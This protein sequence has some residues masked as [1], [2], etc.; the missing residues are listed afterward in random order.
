MQKGPLSGDMHRSSQPQIAHQS[1]IT[2]ALD[3]GSQLDGHSSSGL[4]TSTDRQGHHANT[5]L[6]LAQLA[7]QRL[8]SL[9]M[10]LTYFVNDENDIEFRSIYVVRSIYDSESKPGFDLPRTEF[11]NTKFDL[12]ADFMYR[13]GW[14]L[15][16]PYAAFHLSAWNAHFPTPVELWLWRGAGLLLVGSPVLGECFRRVI[17]LLK[18]ADDAII[19]A[20]RWV[21]LVCSTVSAVL[22]V[23]QW[24]LC[25]TMAA[26]RLYFLVEAFIS[27]REPAPRLYETVTWTQFWPHL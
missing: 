15:S 5:A 21:K 11:S 13:L 9:N 2:Y 3:F 25:S 16:M 22:L 26:S 18:S 14:F 27:L 7:V 19:N 17:N 1:S 12:Q 23:V 10:H 6:M 8:K 24:S 4:P 20:P